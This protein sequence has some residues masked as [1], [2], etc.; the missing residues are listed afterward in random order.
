MNLLSPTAPPPTPS[1]EVRLPRAA[2]ELLKRRAVQSARLSIETLCVQDTV[3][4]AVEH[5]VWDTLRLQSRSLDSEDIQH[6]LIDIQEAV[7]CLEVLGLLRHPFPDRLHV[8]AFKPE[9][10]AYEPCLSVRTAF[11]AALH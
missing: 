2:Y 10:N 11:A 1:D 7:H 6:D 4:G 3:I 8:V 9:I 5:M